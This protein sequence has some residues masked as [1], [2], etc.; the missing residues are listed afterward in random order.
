FRAHPTRRLSGLSRESI[1]MLL[2]HAGLG[3]F[4]IGVSVTESTS[5]EKDIRLSP[6]ETVTIRDLRFSLIS[7]TPSSG[8]NFSAQSGL[9]QVHR[10]DQLIAEMNPQKRTYLRGQVMTEAAINPGLTRDLYVALGEP[11]GNSGAWAL[12]I[13]HKPFIRWIWLGALLM[14][15][16]GFFAA[17]DPRLRE[18]KSQ[19]LTAPMPAVAAGA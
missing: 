11:L 12:R 4:V 8:P 17:A 3:L 7:V 9:V 5:I 14:M 6:G 10:G 2:A 16:G 19:Q 13:Y 15:A 1:G 18:K